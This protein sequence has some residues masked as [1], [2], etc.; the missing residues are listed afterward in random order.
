MNIKV[1]AFL[2]N[3]AIEN[4]KQLVFKIVL[5]ILKLLKFKTAH[6]N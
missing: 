2:I 3:S 5:Y 4:S 1:A 6:F